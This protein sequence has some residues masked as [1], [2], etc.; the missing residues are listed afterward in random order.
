MNWFWFK[1]LQVFCPGILNDHHSKFTKLNRRKKKTWWRSDFLIKYI[2]YDFF[3]FLF[4]KNEIQQNFPHFVA[5]FQSHHAQTRI[6]REKYF[7]KVDFPPRMSM[8]RGWNDTN[9]G[10]QR[11]ILLALS[12][13][14]KPQDTA[15]S[16]LR[17]YVTIWIKGAHCKPEDQQI[18]GWKQKLQPT[19]LFTVFVSKHSE[20]IDSLPPCPVK[21]SNSTLFSGIR[22]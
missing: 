22:E 19:L 20:A 6:F 4:N 18:P 21:L 17:R 10:P 13:N 8:A 3:F 16:R 7:E 2:F 5:H 1:A 9:R 15:N 14:E 11:S 12:S